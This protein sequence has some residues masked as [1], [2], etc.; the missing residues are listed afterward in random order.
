MQLTMGAVKAQLGRWPKETCAKAG[1]WPMAT[2]VAESKQRAQL[3][4][5]THAGQ[6]IT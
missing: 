6:A 5:A 1:R 4:A 2:K 3:P